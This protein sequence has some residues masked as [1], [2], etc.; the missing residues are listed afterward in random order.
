[1]KAR[2][3]LDRLGPFLLIVCSLSIWLFPLPIAAQNVLEHAAGTAAQSEDEQ[4]LQLQTGWNM[5]ALWVNPPSKALK[6]ILAPVRDDVL[7]VRDQDGRIYSDIYSIHGFTEWKESA[8]Y[9]VYVRRPV[10][11]VVKG[12]P[13]RAE[14]VPIDIEKGWN[15]VPFIFPH[16]MPVVDAFESIL[17]IL[18]MATDDE[19]MIH[20]G[21]DLRSA[22]TDSGEHLG[23]LQPGRGYRLYASSEGRLIYPAQSTP[24]D[25][26]PAPGDEKPAPGDED[27]APGDEKPAPG[28]EEPAPGDEE[29]APG[30]EEPAPGDEKPAPGDE[31]PAPGDEEPA[32]GDEEPAPGDEEARQDYLVPASI[33]PTGQREVTMELLDYFATVPDGSRIVFPEA[34]RYNVEGT[35]LIQNRSNLTFVGNG[36]TFFADEAMPLDYATR[37]SNG[38]LAMFAWGNRAHWRI[39]GSSNI[40]LENLNI[41]GANPNAGYQPEAYVRWLEWQ[42]GVAIRG[43]SNVVLS[44]V[45]IRD[46]Y[47]D[48]VYIGRGGSP[49]VP[50]VGVVIKDGIM[51]RNGRQGIAITQGEDILIEGNM[52]TD[53]RM[54]QIDLEPNT[55]NDVI[56]DITIRNNTFE[57]VRHYWF[58]AAGAPGLVEDVV[59]E[60]NWAGRGFML[61]K[62]EDPSLRRN[63]E[64]RRNVTDARFRSSNFVGAWTV[65]HADGFVAED[66]VIPADARHAGPGLRLI[67]V[68]NHS[69][70]AGQWPGADPE[71]HIE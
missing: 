53:V 2:I 12:T 19:G 34:A 52:I 66:N 15:N 26:D 50:A 24:G 59:V 57:R 68:L 28:D 39:D 7:L 36:A 22:I 16:Q 35:I 41:R 55:R 8:S 32:P 14:D 10:T 20:L 44:R 23:D 3:T 70:P 46:V 63:F 27:P 42:H 38:D 9:Q 56:R 6:D 11:F 60:D 33:D 31:D 21:D 37:D 29:P 40:R 54:S 1:M 62:S 51:E 67:N 18:V 69:A 43:A 17:S 25:E 4:V 64:F 58:V 65:D 49:T 5:V 30:D 13:L 48:F 71:I 45:N 61:I 47:G